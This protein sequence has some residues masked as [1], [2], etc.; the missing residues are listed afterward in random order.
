[1]FTDMELQI[2]EFL[3]SPNI[4]QIQE[5][6]E[7]VIANIIESNH[8]VLTWGALAKTPERRK[9][10][11]LLDEIRHDKNFHNIIENHKEV[12][13][14]RM[15]FD[16]G[17]M[18]KEP[19]VANFITKLFNDYEF[20]WATDREDQIEAFVSQNPLTAD[21]RDRLKLYDQI[22]SDIESMERVIL[23][24]PIRINMGKLLY[25][26]TIFT[27]CLLISSFQTKQLQL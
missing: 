10:K 1:M 2:P 7:A 20:L 8:A 16:G 6:Y 25:F 3:V 15:G 23:F 26:T 11:P 24:G 5:K 21:I 4:L 13:R 14:Y 12:L 18:Q 9:K 17:I 27:V 19:D 22:T